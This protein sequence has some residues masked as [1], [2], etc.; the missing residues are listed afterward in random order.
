MRIVDEET[1]RVVMQ[2]RI[3]ALEADNLF[4][5]NFMDQDAEDGGLEDG[6]DGKDGG[7]A[8]EYVVEQADDS[9]EIV[10]DADA[11][12]D[13]DAANQ[14]KKAAKAG[15]GGSKGKR[16]EKGKRHGVGKQGAAP[17]KGRKGKG[18]AAQQA[19]L[20]ST[21]LTK[22]ILAQH[23]QSQSKAGHST[24]LKKRRPRLDLQRL[25]Y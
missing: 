21:D 17:R 1:R 4:D 19:A 10:S 24:L 22:Q 13:G 9:E 23:A 16:L 11:S 25:F 12:G 5:N 15:A 6:A 7:Y 8:G 14:E 2:N 3:D 18:G 20:Q